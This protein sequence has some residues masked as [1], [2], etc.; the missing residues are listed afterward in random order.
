MGV[1][2]WRAR[3]GGCNPH[4]PKSNTRAQQGVSQHGRRLRKLST[5]W[6]NFARYLVVLR[7]LIR[8]LCIHRLTHGTVIR[9][10]IYYDRVF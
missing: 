1:G 3:S 7:A 5:F 8:F 2:S 4:G 6:T 9:N 10:Y